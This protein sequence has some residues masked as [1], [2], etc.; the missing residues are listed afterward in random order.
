MTP[1]TADR[2][3]QCG[4]ELAA[5]PDAN[6]APSCPRCFLRF[7]LPGGPAE[8]A[9]AVDAVASDEGEE[10]TGVLAASLPV[11]PE[12]LAAPRSSWA[13]KFVRVQRVAIGAMAE[14]WRAWDLALGRW[15]AL[16]F[17][18]PGER[19]LARFLREARIAGRLSH[20]HI[21]SVY[22]VGSD[23]GRHFM[24]LQFVVGPTL[25]ELPRR[26]RRRLVR[27]LRDA[28]YAVQ[29]AHEQGVVHRDLKPGNMMVTGPDTAHP[30]LWVLDFGLSVDT[31]AGSED[32]GRLAMAGSP[33][34]MPLEQAQ[35]GADVRSDVYGLGATLYYLL[36][37]Q[38]PYSGATV[39]QIL[40]RLLTEPPRPP[41]ALDPSIPAE[42]EAVVLRCLARE[43]AA[44]YESARALA[45]D[46]DR[47]LRRAT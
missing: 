24:A 16:K 33:G 46:L 39:Y 29:Y 6:G 28:A 21:P 14:V 9:R 43:S 2:C 42:L 1:P 10:W 27:L 7:V 3:P 45:E 47:W 32:G 5:A 25:R 34:F 17:P 12:V 38:A 11:P 22:E 30:H 23:G 4:D 41:R 31:E 19:S 26:D 44:R 18:L 36:T 8:A 13:G 35:G 15:V 20:P 37:G 40:A